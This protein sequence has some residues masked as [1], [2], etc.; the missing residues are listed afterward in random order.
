[1]ITMSKSSEVTCG[2]LLK[3]TQSPY[4]DLEK[5]KTLVFFDFLKLWA[6]DRTSKYASVKNFRPYVLG[7]CAL[8]DS[9]ASDKIN[10]DKLNP[11]DVKHNEQLA[12]DVMK[13]L[14]IL[15]YILPDDCD[16]E[17]DPKCVLTQL[18]AAR[19]VLE[20]LPQFPA[21]NIEER[22]IVSKLSD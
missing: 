15:V 1:M 14:D 18:A 10:F 3:D 9:F 21:V 6:D 8:L 11:S 16:G 12:V 2:H 4:G 13:E 17:M 5:D 7:M 19:I 20:N 22:R